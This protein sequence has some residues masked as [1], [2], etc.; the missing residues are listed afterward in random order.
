M[1]QAQPLQYHIYPLQHT[2]TPYSLNATFSSVPP[3]LLYIRTMSSTLNFDDKNRLKERVIALAG[4]RPTRHDLLALDP[5]RYGQYT[6]TQENG[7][8]IYRGP[9]GGKVVKIDIQYLSNDGPMTTG[10]YFTVVCP[11]FFSSSREMYAHAV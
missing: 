1:R 7:E 4:P 5:R 2:S 10:R 6:C 3:H 8:I 9:G 11:C